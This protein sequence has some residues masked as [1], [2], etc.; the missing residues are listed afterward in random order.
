MP[1]PSSV[2]R[3][4]GIILKAVRGWKCFAKNVKEVSGPF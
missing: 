3:R 4:G 1:Y 2:E